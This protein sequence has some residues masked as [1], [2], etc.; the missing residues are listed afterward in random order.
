[1]KRPNLSSTRYLDRNRCRKPPETG[2]VP[3]E[4]PSYNTGP[5]SLPAA[6]PDAIPMPPSEIDSLFGS[7]ASE[8]SA[9]P[10]TLNSTTLHKRGMSRYDFASDGT[11]TDP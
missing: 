2:F 10:P 5:G 9:I 1:M 7:D 8:L 6:T 3:E 11:G 4:T